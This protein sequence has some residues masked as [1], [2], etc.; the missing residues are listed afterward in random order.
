MVI[1]IR[2]QIII[3]WWSIA[4]MI[5]YSLAMLF[6]LR[7]VPPP[8]A[9][10]TANQVARW[11]TERQTPIRIGA[12]ISGLTAAFMLP[13][14]AVVA[15]QV[16]RQEQGHKIWTLL[17]AAAGTMMTLFIMMS[18]ICWGVAAFE[19]QRSPEITAVVHQL[20]LL[21]FV[22]T[23]QISPFCWAAVAVICFLPQPAP[24]SPFPRWLGYFTAWTALVFEV[25]ATSFNFHSGPLAWN[26]LLV[27]WLP[28]VFFGIWLMVMCPLMFKSLKLQLADALAAEAAHD[29]SA[30][31]KTVTPASEILGT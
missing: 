11:Y 8:P 16:S 9:T 2:S 17:A 7:M 22:T 19:P 10:D 12:T 13:F 24:H 20:G 30:Q 25:G 6:L 15:I 31:G 27:Y 14:W 1:S 28:L 29:T 18:P 3:L 21:S 26:G 5:L 4:F 23:D